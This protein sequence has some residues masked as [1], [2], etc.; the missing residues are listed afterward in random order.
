M[1]SNLSNGSLSKRQFEKAQQ[2][3]ARAVR[4]RTEKSL[5]VLEYLVYLVGGSLC[6]IMRE[7]GASGDARESML[8]VGMIEDGLL[9]KGRVRAE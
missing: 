9:I 6:L 5:F 8:T 4:A 7:S 3:T 1:Y 2:I